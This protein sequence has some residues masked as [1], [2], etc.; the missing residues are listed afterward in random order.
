MKLKTLIYPA[1]C[2]SFLTTENKLLPPADM[3]RVSATFLAPTQARGILDSSFVSLWLT[4]PG[5]Q[6]TQWWRLTARDYC[7]SH[8]DD[9]MVHRSAAKKH[10]DCQIFSMSKM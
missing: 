1:F 3:E 4:T 7:I 9:K 8:F 6:G 10:D 5:S 2:F